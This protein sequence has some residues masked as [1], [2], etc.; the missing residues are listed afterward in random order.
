MVRTV[1]RNLVSNAIKFTERGGVIRVTANGHNRFIEVSVI[2]TG[3]GI[4]RESKE[5]LFKVGM[6]LSTKGTA[7]EK[8]NGLGL[9]LCKEF[10]EKNH[11][12]IWVESP[13]PDATEKGSAFRFTLP[14]PSTERAGGEAEY[15]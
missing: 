3:I 4:A 12:K 9:I 13:F 8:G 15:N 6:S 5:K 14:R 11:G 7:K 10:V 2:D 1:L